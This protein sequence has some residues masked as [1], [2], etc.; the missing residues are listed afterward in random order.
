MR[1]HEPECDAMHGHNEDRLRTGACI[2]CHVSRLAY[3]RGREDANATLA[4]IRDLHAEVVRETDTVEGYLT[5]ICGYCDD[6]YPCD[7]IR[8]L[9]GER[10]CKHGSHTCGCG[11][12]A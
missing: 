9:N 6:S 1:A 8:A 11:E 10:K 3:R 2:F 4:R 7:T 12:Q 5:K